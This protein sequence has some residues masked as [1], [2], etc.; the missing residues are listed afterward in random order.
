M[1]HPWRG[2]LGIFALAFV[3]Y[4]LSLS[5]GVFSW[6]SAE[7]TL[8]SNL[9]VQEGLIENQRA[10]LERVSAIAARDLAYV[11]LYKALG[12]A[13]MPAPPAPTTAQAA[14]GAD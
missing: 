8:G 11:S 2:A 10:Q 3:I 9:D 12:G 7:L 6:D 13:P 14:G 4:A 5:P 1:S